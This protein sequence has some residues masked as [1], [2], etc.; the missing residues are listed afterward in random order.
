MV[1]QNGWFIIENLIKMDDL[2]VP[3]HMCK[4][5]TNW[6]LDVQRQTGN[7]DMIKTS[8]GSCEA[9][10]TALHVLQ[11]HVNECSMIYKCSTSTSQSYYV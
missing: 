5:H 4:S 11:K 7:V 1:P 9:W 10:F 2:G 6:K 8:D 3:F